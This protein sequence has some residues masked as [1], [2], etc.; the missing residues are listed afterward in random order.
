MFQSNQ[1]VEDTRSWAIVG[2]GTSKVLS[3]S[4]FGNTINAEHLLTKA[5]K[6]NEF[7]ITLDLEV[8]D[9]FQFAINSSWA[10]QRGGGY[11]ETTSKDGTEYFEVKGSHLSTN[12][13]K[14]NIGVLV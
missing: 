4:G 12:T 5:D 8:G 9:E 6:K 1:V 14:C 13:K 3:T 7:S 2:N 10:N 11:L